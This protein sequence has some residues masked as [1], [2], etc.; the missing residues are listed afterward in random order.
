[1]KIYAKEADVIVTLNGER[2]PAVLE[3]G[4][5][6]IETERTHVPVSGTYHGTITMTHEHNWQPIDGECG[7]YA[8]GCLAQARRD[9]RTGKLELVPPR[10]QVPVEASTMPS[11]V[12]VQLTIGCRM[13]AALPR[14][15]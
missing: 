5:F 3:G 10:W 1:M 11:E 4:L 2:F 7:R 13:R 14:A 15:K 6:E 12:S 8:C 9:L